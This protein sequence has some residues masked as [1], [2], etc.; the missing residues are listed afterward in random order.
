AMGIPL[1]PAGRGILPTLDTSASKTCDIP[2]A[3]WTLAR[4]DGSTPLRPG[5]LMNEE[6]SMPVITRRSL[7]AGTAATGTLTALP[8]AIASA[9]TPIAATPLASPV[10]SPEASPV[11]SPVAGMPCGIKYDLGAELARHELS[12][13]ASHER[14]YRDE[15]TAIRDQLHCTQVDLHGSDPD[16]LVAGLVVAA[17]LGFDIHLQTRLN[18]LPLA[19]MRDRL[20]AVAIEADRVRRAGIP[21]VLDVGCEYL[22]FADGLIEG[23]D[24]N[25]KLAAIEAGAVDW[26]VT[27]GRFVR[28]LSGLAETARTH[29]GGAISYSDTPDMTGAWD[30][31]D[32]I[33]IDHYLS[34]ESRDSYVRTIDTLATMGKPV[35]IKEFGSSA[36]RGAAEAGGMAWNIL[37]DTTDPPQIAAGI[38]RDEAAQADAILDTLALIGQSQAERAYLYEFIT[39]GSPRHP[40]PRYDYDLTGYGIVSTWGEDDE[41]FYDTTGFWEPKE[42][43]PRLAA[44]NQGHETS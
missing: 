18:F 44:W 26:D 43:F 10:A 3:C 27:I 28:L 21:V 22:L 19:D 15:L 13:P 12:R 23:D 25:E 11:A 20:A 9:S 32:I 7:I 29:F 40:D 6:T 37:D 30:P 39:T 41:R 2:P 42:A 24:F 31:F 16:Q 36:W 14:F 34:A 35:W 8:A 33:G 1:C 4:R 38:E 17:D 5:P